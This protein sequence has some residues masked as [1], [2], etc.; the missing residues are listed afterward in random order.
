MPNRALMTDMHANDRR[1]SSA[2]VRMLGWLKPRRAA[3]VRVV[4][5]KKLEPIADIVA[6]AGRSERND[7]A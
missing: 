6:Q 2:L 4:S 7:A 3:P 1:P 5:D